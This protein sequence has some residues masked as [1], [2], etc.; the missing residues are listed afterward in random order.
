MLFNNAIDEFSRE[1][2]IN[3][4]GRIPLEKEIVECCERGTPSCIQ[5]PESTHTLSY[6]QIS[7]K[8][9]EYLDDLESLKNQSS[10]IS[11]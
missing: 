9:L 10:N 1:M 3:V 5:H 4:I 8:I 2:D 7:R 11:Q 6:R